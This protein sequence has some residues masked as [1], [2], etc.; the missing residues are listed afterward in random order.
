MVHISRTSLGENKVLRPEDIGRR[1]PVWEALAELW[2]DTDLT[3]EDLNWMVR[4]L[5]SSGYSIDEIRDIYLFE[6]APVIHNLLFSQNVVWSTY[7]SHVL[8]EKIIHYCQRPH[9]I[10]HFFIRLW[11]GRLRLTWATDFQ[12]WRLVRELK[13][14]R[15]DQNDFSDVATNME[16]L[17]SQLEA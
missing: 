8:F 13:Q 7:Q 9:R 4:V 2:L 17:Q 6:V 3:E 1:K 15:E 16:G 5:R 14:N 10:S 11:I 12:W